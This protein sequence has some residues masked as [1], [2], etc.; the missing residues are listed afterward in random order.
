MYNIL[1]RKACAPE[2]GPIMARPLCPACRLAAMES[3]VYEGVWTLEDPPA[4][5]YVCWK[6]GFFCIYEDFPEAY[7]THKYER[8]KTYEVS[9]A[10]LPTNIKEI[11]IYE[12]RI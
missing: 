5:G 3:N 1:G 9:I 6:C 11:A 12:E 10:W 7:Y 4:V 8:S 2:G